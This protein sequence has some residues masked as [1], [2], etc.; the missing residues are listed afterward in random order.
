MELNKLLD[1][2]ESYK[3]LEDNWDSYGAKPPG[4]ATCDK[5][6]Q[7]AT[8]ICHYLK[9]NELH[10]GQVKVETF[11]SSKGISIRLTILREASDPPG[12]LT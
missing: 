4:E 5:A 7:I 10:R 9:V 1:E 11:P 3:E 12:G 2:I 6:E 8:L